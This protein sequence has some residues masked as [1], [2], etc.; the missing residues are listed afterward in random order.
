MSEEAIQEVLIQEEPNTEETPMPPAKKTKKGFTL[1]DTTLALL[2]Q[3]CEQTGHGQSR[4]VNATLLFAVGAYGPDGYT[5]FIVCNRE[6]YEKAT[7]IVQQHAEAAVAQAEMPDQVDGTTLPPE[8]TIPHKRGQRAKLQIPIPGEAA[9]PESYRPNLGGD[10]GTAPVDSPTLPPGPAPTHTSMSPI[11]AKHEAGM[12]MIVQ[13]VMATMMAMGMAPQMQP[14][15]QQMVPIVPGDPHGPQ[16]PQQPAQAVQQG[17]PTPIG[18][19]IPRQPQQQTVN[20]NRQFPTAYPPGYTG[21]PGGTPAAP[22]PP[23]QQGMYPM[24]QEQ[25]YA[26][27]QFAMNIGQQVAQGMQRQPLTAQ[28][29]LSGEQPL[30]PNMN[31]QYVN[32]HMEAARQA[33]GSQWRQN[34]QRMV[35]NNPRTM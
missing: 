22:P 13:Q 5:D 12:D 28:G 20:P 8:Q 34:V 35:A 9:Q 6:I 2:K 29:L 10:R 15:M 11:S 7:E 27:D 4:V 3:K 25:P 17:V 21:P 32:P 31:Q 33:L 14:Q 24:P 26:Q 18:Y 23:E 16:M 30:S 1:P 19:E